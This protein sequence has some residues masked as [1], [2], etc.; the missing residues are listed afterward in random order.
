MSR[1]ICEMAKP[2]FTLEF[3]KEQSRLIKLAETLIQASSFALDIET[4]D[5]WNRHRERIALIQ[6]AFFFSIINKSGAN[7]APDLTGLIAD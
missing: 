7:N 2:D 5:W 3:I 4:I 1:L 6:I